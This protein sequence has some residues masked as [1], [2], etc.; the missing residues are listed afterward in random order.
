[1]KNP[2]H[3]AELL[4]EL[5]SL[6]EN[7]FERHRIN[8]LERDLTAPPVAEIIDDTHQKF[9]DIVYSCSPSTRG[10]FQ[11]ARPLHRDI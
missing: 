4:A 6:A 11:T 2:E 3:V 7:D 9:N 1:M 5:R 10:Y 8:V